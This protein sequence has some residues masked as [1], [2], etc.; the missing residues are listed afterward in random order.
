MGGHP[1]DVHNKTDYLFVGGEISPHIMGSQKSPVLIVKV[2][3]QRKND[4]RVFCS[5]DLP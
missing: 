3:E 1:A 4:L 5:K 2:W